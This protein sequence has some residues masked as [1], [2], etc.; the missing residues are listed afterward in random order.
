MIFFNDDLQI[1]LQLFALHVGVA[2]GK[3][4]TC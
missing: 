2:N 1:M 4:E 3:S